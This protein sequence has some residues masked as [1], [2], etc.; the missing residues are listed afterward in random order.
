[1]YIQKVL[2]VSLVALFI[3]VYVPTVFQF[4]IVTMCIAL[5]IPVYSLVPFILL[6]TRASLPQ[7]TFTQSYLRLDHCNREL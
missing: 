6:Y 7:S 4:H 1:M 2:L 5:E 3:A